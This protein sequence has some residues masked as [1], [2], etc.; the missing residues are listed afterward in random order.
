MQCK[1]CNLNPIIH[2]TH[3]R[4]TTTENAT[5]HHA[6]F[7]SMKQPTKQKLTAKVNYLLR[8]KSLL[9]YEYTQLNQ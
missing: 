2:T 9:H 8:I 7:S 6:L 4:T 3:L 1:T 5:T